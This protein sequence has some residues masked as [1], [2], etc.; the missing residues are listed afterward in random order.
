MKLALVFPLA[1]LVPR[2]LAKTRADGTR[3]VVVTPLSPSAAFWPG[4]A[5]ASRSASPA[6]FDPCIVVPASPPYVSEA[7]DPKGAQRPAVMAVDFSRGEGVAPTRLDRP[8][9][10]AGHR[11]PTAASHA[12]C[13]GRGGRTAHSSRAGLPRA[14]E[15]AG[16]GPPRPPASSPD[17][18][19][20]IPTDA[21][22]A[23]PPPVPAARG[24]GERGLCACVGGT[25]TLPMPAPGRPLACPVPSPVLAR[26]VPPAPQ[27]TAV[28]SHT[29]GAPT[30]PQC[31]LRPD[32]ER[33]ALRA[34]GPSA[35]PG[36]RA[37]RLISH[38]TLR[39]FQALGMGW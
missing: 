30:A 11:T 24:G 5:A 16:R 27:P 6:S 33:G 9:W 18:P 23:A 7:A 3:G 20:N 12:P 21:S 26:S 13:G 36:A 2:A 15:A 8:A 14:S 38:F 22:P 10:R 35:R 32:R 37:G 28:R 17:P 34:A 1:S 39:P 4:F 31:G 19:V 25:R 29:P